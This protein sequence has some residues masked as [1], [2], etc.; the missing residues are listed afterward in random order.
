MHWDNLPGSRRF[1][2]PV[3]PRPNS[4]T[5]DRK[6][7]T[8]AGAGAVFD[9][10]LHWIGGH[11]GEA[12][13][14]EI[15]SIDADR[16]RRPGDLQ[17]MPATPPSR[18]RRPG[19]AAR[20]GAHGRQHRGTASRLRHWPA[21]PGFRRAGF[22]ACFNPQLSTSPSQHYRTLRLARPMPCCSKTDLAVTEVALS[23]GF[24][25]PEH[26]SRVYR[27]AFGRRA[28]RRPPPK[29][30][31]AR[32]AP[33]RVKQGSRITTETET[34]GRISLPIVHPAIPPFRHAAHWRGHPRL[35]STAE[36]W[37]LGSAFG[38]PKHDKMASSW[39]ESLVF[40]VSLVLCGDSSLLTRR[41]ARDG[42]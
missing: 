7:L 42:P 8:C 41:L 9:M 6:R 28:Q 2:P 27:G 12:L 33:A 18:P 20:A 29:H 31:C 5:V 23:A 39:E 34:Q 4:T 37:M 10:M 13:A 19:A 14:G 36:S 35:R 15:A 11:H 1:I 30:R 16:I 32:P 3:A 38:L 25:S 24:A 22:S 17:P 26:F 21:G 40:S